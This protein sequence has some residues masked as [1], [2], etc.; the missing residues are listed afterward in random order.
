MKI[1][2]R[3]INDLYL[4]I[5]I[6]YSFLFAGLLQFFFGVSDT[7]I[8]I[9]FTYLFLLWYLIKPKVK[10][11]REYLEIIIISLI[12]VGYIF[13]ISIIKGKGIIRPVIYSQFYFIPL[14]VLLVLYSKGDNTF[15]FISLKKVKVFLLFIAILQLPILLI[16]RNFF[17]F[18][19]E[20]NF[21]G[22][23]IAAVDF[24]FGTFPLKNDHSLGFF[25]V[26]NLLYI[27]SNKVLKNR[28]QLIAVSLLLVTNLLLTNSN[29]SILFAIFA[30]I[31]LIIKNKDNRTKISLKKILIILAFLTI[32]ILFLNNLE[33]KFYLDLKNKIFSKLDVKSAIY[34]YKQGLARREQIVL[35]LL[36]EGINFTGYGAYSY[37]NML[38]GQFN[39]TFRHFSQ[40][41]WT[42]YDLGVIGLGLFIYYIKSLHNLFKEQKASYNSC[43]TLALIIYSFFTI[44]TF[45]L[46]FML[47]YFIYKK[48][49]EY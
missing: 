36:S 22:R 3:I 35:V 5:F 48:K 6:A 14:V 26:V 41:L 10:I 30:I 17:D 40:L 34:W 29:S 19:I 28:T 46:S 47:T 15:R 38:T 4:L 21:S 39:K 43:L 20:F 33:P 31:F 32:L 12:I 7:I 18:L 25:L 11:R 37:F 23:N 13:F 9:C 16:Q 24:E 44:V 42:Y 8:V 45:D 2:L 27:W 49:N 1:N